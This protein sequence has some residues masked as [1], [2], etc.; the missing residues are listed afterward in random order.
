MAVTMVCTHGARDTGLPTSSGSTGSSS[1]R[2]SGDSGTHNGVDD[3][4]ADD[5]DIEMER[6][7]T[8]SA[9]LPEVDD[10]DDYVARNAKRPPSTSSFSSQFASSSKDL[11]RL[12]AIDSVGGA[13]IPRVEWLAHSSSNN[14][15]SSNR[16]SM[17][18][19]QPNSSEGGGGG[20]KLS[21]WASEWATIVITGGRKDK[22]RPGDLLGALTA[23]AAG[24]AASSS[25]T[26]KKSSGDG[27][28][29]G[30]YK[31][32]AKGAVSSGA[33]K[34]SSSSSSP[35]SSGGGAGLKGV[36]VGKI[37]VL[38]NE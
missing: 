9:L 15:L 21:K 20:Q 2:S 1:S 35:S 28:R 12:N 22:L 32:P 8:E 31:K 6:S 30:A 26:S 11:G 29:R 16:N 4:S 17:S 18:R 27:G 38:Q 10:D 25:T 36:D 33:S 34:K 37:E 13:P 7:F 24:K 23:G 19:G 3:K 5:S 14:A